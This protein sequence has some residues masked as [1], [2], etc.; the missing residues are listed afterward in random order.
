MHIRPR[1]E[2]LST[3]TS[4]PCFFVHVFT[5]STNASFG[6]LW[7]F[8]KKVLVKAIKL[9]QRFVLFHYQY[10]GKTATRLCSIWHKNP[11]CADTQLSVHLCS[12]CVYIFHH[13]TRR[14]QNSSCQLSR[15]VRSEKKCTRYSSCLCKKEK[16]PRHREKGNITSKFTMLSRIREVFLC[17]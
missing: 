6:L 1:G 17:S 13:T 16:S 10:T 12:A 14:H 5:N 4:C 9:Q 11:S 2:T 15:V 7:M 3:F 8:S